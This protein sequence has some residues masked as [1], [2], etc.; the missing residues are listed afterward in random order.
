MTV[1]QILNLSA[2]VINDALKNL[3]YKNLDERSLVRLN[4]GLKF[5]YDAE[6]MPP[7]FIT[8]HLLGLAKHAYESGNQPAALILHDWILGGPK[9]LPI[10]G[11]AWALWLLLRTGFWAPSEQILVKLCTFNDGRRI[12]GAVLC[13][14]HLGPNPTEYMAGFPGLDEVAMIAWQRLQDNRNPWDKE[15]DLVA[16]A[17]DNFCRCIN[18]QKVKHGGWVITAPG[19]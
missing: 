3:S 17:Q 11:R 9:S 16:N 6:R 19:I 4:D 18:E 13:G 1:E 8:E 5:R 12:I 10:I 14:E 2:V 7:A 15:S